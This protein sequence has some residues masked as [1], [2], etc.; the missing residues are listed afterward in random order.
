MSEY[1]KKFLDPRW[2]KKRL[3]IL[4]RDKF[5]CCK[6]GDTENTLH[7]HHK[8]YIWNQEPWDAKDE[9]LETLCAECHESEGWDKEGFNWSVR[10]LLENGWNYEQLSQ[11][12]SGLHS[13]IDFDKDE[14]VRVASCCACFPD[15]LERMKKEI[16]ESTAFFATI[17][18]F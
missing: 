7:V 9:S 4:E 14:R 11:Y 18:P 3:Q 6:C 12:I 15:I 8:Y 1:K 5:S 10:N 13:E 16:D 17:L 2:Q